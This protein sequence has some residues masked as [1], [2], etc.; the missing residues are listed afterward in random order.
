MTGAQKQAYSHSKNF[1][2]SQ[3]VNTV[4]TNLDQSFA[5]MMSSLWDYM[6]LQELAPERNLDVIKVDVSHVNNITNKTQL[7]WFGHSSFLLQTANQTLL[8]DPIFSDTAAPH[9]TLGSKRYSKNL[10]IEPAQLPPIDAVIISHD[11]YDHLDS[12]AIKDLSKIVGRFF[13][14]LGVKAHLERWGG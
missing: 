1:L 11:H 6:T 8:F 4:E 3:F 12:K 2:Q 10:P 7:L 13:V 14:P 5:L 9:P